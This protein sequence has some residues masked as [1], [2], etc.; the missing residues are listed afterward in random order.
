MPSTNAVLSDQ[1]GVEAL[2]RVLIVAEYVSTRFGGEAVLPWHYFRMLR[3]RGIEAWLVT[4]ARTQN[5]LI[6][7]LPSEVSRFYF[8]P[9]TE[10]DKLCGRL[11]RYLP[12]QLSYITLGYMSR[13][14]TQLAARRVVRQVVKE[15]QVDVVHQPIPVSPREPSLMHGLGAPVVIGPMNGNMSYPS[16]VKKN[17]RQRLLTG[18]YGLARYTTVVLHRLMPGKLRAAVL[19]VA[20]ERTKRALPAGA[21]G[22]VS[23]L[24]ENGVDLAVWSPPD[25]PPPVEAPARFIFLGRLVDW[26][27]V[28]LLLEAFARVQAPFLPRLEI[29]GDGPMRSALEAQVRDLCLD[30]RVQFAGWQSQPECARRLRDGDA[31]VLPSIYECGGAVVLEAMACGLPVIATE[32][33]G[34]VD[35]LDSSCGI[36]VRPSSRN[37]LISGF[38]DAMS[39]LASSPTLRA[40]LGRVGRERVVR[41]F[42][43]EHKIDRMLA[44]YRRVAKPRKFGDS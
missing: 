27:A 7:L 24:V 41:E 23:I 9:D 30:D 12:G 21:R 6:E 14:K 26:K 33:G 37:A 11:G 39:R 16:F 13:I 20:N 36:L 29:I 1:D 17:P 19:L 3:D 15:K 22:E 35:Y 10:F 8:V 25:R 4:H 38:A 5:E 43:W 34:P 32:W 2:P 44:V 31:L 28:D 40:S 42:N 18:L